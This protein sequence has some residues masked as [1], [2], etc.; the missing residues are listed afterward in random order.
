VFEKN[1]FKSIMR[2]EELFIP[3]LLRGLKNILPVYCLKKKLSRL[4]PTALTL[5]SES[6]LSRKR[7][8]RIIGI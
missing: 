4:I 3:N 7:K 1:V 8:M 5:N 2:Q 6:N